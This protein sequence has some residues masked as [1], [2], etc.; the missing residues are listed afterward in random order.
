MSTTCP[1]CGG[2]RAANTPAARAA[3]LTPKEIRER[4]RPDLRAEPPPSLTDAIR[5]KRKAEAETPEARRDR[6]R[7]SMADSIH[8]VRR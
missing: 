5:E 2:T 1:K 4:L 3:S 8:E 7:Q 6:V